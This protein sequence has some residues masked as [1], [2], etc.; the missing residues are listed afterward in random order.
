MVGWRSLADR[1]RLES[2]RGKPPGVQIPLPPRRNKP[3]V[4]SSE[5]EQLALNQRVGISKFPGPT[6]GGCNVA[7]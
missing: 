3:W 5:A 1:T 7:R 6:K 4:R 2:E